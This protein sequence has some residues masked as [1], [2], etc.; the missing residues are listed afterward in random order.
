MRSPLSRYAPSPEGDN[1]FAAER[2]LLGVSR[3]G[4]AAFKRMV[5]VV[6]VQSQGA[7]QRGAAL[8]A[9]MLTVVMVATLASA[10]LWQQWRDVEVET[11]ERNRVQAAWLLLSA[12]DW[13]RVVLQEDSRANRN[14]PIDHLGEP[15]AVP[16]QEARLSTFLAAQKNVT[17]VGDGMADMQDAFLSGE[18][19]DLQSRLNLRNLYSGRDQAIAPEALKPFVRLFNRL[20]LPASAVTQIAS[21]LQQAA[22]GS[23]QNAPLMPR[24]VR[25]LAWLGIDPQLL[26][27]I[28]P[29]VTLLPE[30]TQVNINTASAEVLY[31]SDEDLDWAGASQLVQLRDS[32]PFKSVAAAR[33]AL[34]RSNVLDKSA[35]TVTT[36][37]FEAR[38]RLRLGDNILS[39]RSLIQRKDM[40]VTTLWQEQAGWGMPAI[41]QR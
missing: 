16:L 29:Y 20:G 11:A 9:A 10:A 1:T 13:S 8:L 21:G 23:A 28:E 36:S 17:Q 27:R 19:I 41:A 37:Y 5:C 39:Q 38:G 22:R 7:R 18:V 25:Q 15:W 26:M 30:A 12:L 2:P 31:A 24:T 34:G 32:T 3:M 6:P 33:T 35:H 4:R 14:N 40:T